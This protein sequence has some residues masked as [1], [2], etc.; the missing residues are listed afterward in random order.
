MAGRTT[1]IIAHRLVTV[2]NAD[3]IVVL[4]AG[5][6]AELG[7]HAQLLEQDGYY[8]SLVRR[9][10]HGLIPNDAVEHP[11]RRATDFPSPLENGG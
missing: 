3:R 8:A 9:Q 11:R 7:T 5:R 6:V 4:R 1:F 2:A 10:S